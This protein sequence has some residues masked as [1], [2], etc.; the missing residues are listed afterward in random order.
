MGLIYD[1]STIVDESISEYEQLK[2][3]NFKVLEETGEDQ[4]WKNL[5]ALGD[6]GRLMK[7]LLREY[8]MAGKIQ[9][10]YIETPFFTK[11]N[12][13]TAVCINT[14]KA[15]K[16]PRIKQFAYEDTWEKNLPQY[17]KMLCIRLL[18]IRDLLSDTGTVWIH[19]DW[20]AS[21]YVRILM[22]EIFGH[23]RFVNEIIWNYK[24]GGSSKKHFARKHDN[25]LVYSKD[26]KYLLKVP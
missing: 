14:S 10:I 8:N 15:G 25:I 20:H 7:T 26:K 17:L 6:N 5:L 23:D 19:L 3:G 1:F 24:S 13:D 22:D 21:H 12:Y 11:A 18:L 2:S 4:G 16:L 9:K